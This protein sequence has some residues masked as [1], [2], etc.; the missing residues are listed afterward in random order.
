MTEDSFAQHPVL[1]QLVQTE[2]PQVWARAIDADILV[3]ERRLAIA[4]RERFMLN[5]PISDLRRIQFDIERSRPAT[6]VVV[7]ERAD[8]EPQVLAIAPEE[9]DSVAKALA[10]IGR[11]LAAGD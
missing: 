1:G 4:T 9:F 5:V 3:T 2:T 8:H 10:V 6:M 11:R 7:P